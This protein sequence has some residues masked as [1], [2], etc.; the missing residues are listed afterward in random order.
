MDVLQIKV[1]ARIMITYNIATQDKIV[2]GSRGIIK[3]IQ[4]DPKTADVLYIIVTFDDKRAGANHRLKY[5]SYAKPFERILGTPIFKIKFSLAIGHMAK[6]HSA[7]TILQQ[8]PM[9]LAWAIT[10]HK[11]QGQTVPKPAKVVIHLSDLFTKNQAYVCLTRVQELEQLYIASFTEKW[12]KCDLTTKSKVEE[13]NEKS[14]QDQS[15]WFTNSSNLK[16]ASLNIRSLKL[17]LID[18]KH[19]FTMCASDVICLTETWLHGDE[20]NDF[21]MTNY[22]SAFS[23]YGRG[24]GTAVFYKIGHLVGTINRENITAVILKVQALTIIT[25]YVSN[26]ISENEF[27]TII[28]QYV[29]SPCLITGDFNFVPDSKKNISEM[30]ANKNVI[31]Y[32]TE[33][34]HE[35]G[36][37]LDHLYSSVKPISIDLHSVV[38]SDHDAICTEIKM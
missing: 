18:L 7:K 12:L 27:I 21:S 25:C 5:A 37:I 30:F 15:S 22:N 29:K 23:S 9:K 1:N 6:N 38:Y 28:Q 20:E 14:I 17:H 33:P 32:V 31:Q 26:K 19:D 36:S 35:K 34:T 24:R 16:I 3:H 11:V 13:L 10:S 8:F 2:N 4:L